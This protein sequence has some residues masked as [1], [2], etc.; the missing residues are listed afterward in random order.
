MVYYFRISLIIFI[1]L[2]GLP[3]ISEGGIPCSLPKCMGKDKRKFPK[4]KGQKSIKYLI[5][6]YTDSGKI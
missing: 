4:Y 1:D 5:L 6:N 3:L 2:L